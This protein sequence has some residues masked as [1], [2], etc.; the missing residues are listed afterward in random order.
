MYHVYEYGACRVV[1]YG[2]SIQEFASRRP[3]AGWGGTMRPTAMQCGHFSGRRS[4]TLK[5][6]ILTRTV[7]Q[8]IARAPAAPT[9]T[10]VARVTTGHPPAYLTLVVV[11]DTRFLAAVTAIEVTLSCVQDCGGSQARTSVRQYGS[12]QNDGH[13]GPPSFQIFYFSGRVRGLINITSSTVL[14]IVRRVLTPDS[15]CFPK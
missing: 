12:R 1:M 7:G 4:L 9:V 13:V 8:V 10:A 14:P 3:G 11:F 2:K 5:A 6:R 15:E